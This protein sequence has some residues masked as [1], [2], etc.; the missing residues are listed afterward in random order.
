MTRISILLTGA[1]ACLL[2]A[3]VGSASAMPTE[4][5]VNTVCGTTSG[6][7][8]GKKVSVTITGENVA[9]SQAKYTE[10]KVAKKVVDTIVSKAA[11]KPTIVEG[12][13]ITPTVLSAQRDTVEYTGIFRGADTA[14]EIRIKFKVTYPNRGVTEILGRP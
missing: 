8:V 1:L 3:A 6:K 14:T 12:F 4:G 5:I 2:L 13:R 9:P 7:V 11:K 10:C